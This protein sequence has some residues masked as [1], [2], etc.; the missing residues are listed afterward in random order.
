MGWNFRRQRRGGER[1]PSSCLLVHRRWA[2]DPWVAHLTLAHISYSRKHWLSQW[3]G[4]GCLG[5]AIPSTS[6]SSQVIS[7][8]GIWLCLP[9]LIPVWASSSSKIF[10]LL[11]LPDLLSVVC[12]RLR[13]SKRIVVCDLHMVETQIKKSKQWK[14]IQ[15]IINRY[16]RN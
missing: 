6:L 10:F 8:A 14:N 7:A 15:T 11:T 13:N 2:F 4:S 9:F 16:H 12:K 1:S 5:V 3:T